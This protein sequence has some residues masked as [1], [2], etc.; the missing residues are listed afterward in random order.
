MDT[1]NFGAFLTFVLITTFT[2]GPNNITSSSMGILYGYR[3]TLKFLSGIVTGFFIIMLLSGVIS[4]TLY[5]LLPSVEVIIRIMGALYILWLAYKTFKS[6]YQFTEDSSP[7]LK[8]VDGFL[9]VMLNPKVWIFSLTLYTT[10]LVPITGNIFFLFLSAIFLAG[11]AFCATS[12]WALSG[13]AIK[14]YLKNPKIQ[15]A[16]NIILAILL[17]YTAIDLSGLFQ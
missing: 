2:P 12:T 10:F 3:K 17:I 1:I 6:S 7:I 14:H 16:I 4:Q 11:V 8:F 5:A 13:A 9:V 15:K